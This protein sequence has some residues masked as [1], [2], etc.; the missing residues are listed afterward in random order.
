MRGHVSP[1]VL[2]IA[3]L[4]AVLVLGA[5]WV[6][7][8]STPAPTPSTEPAVITLPTTATVT[9]SRAGAN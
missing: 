2:W 3:A 8:S 5:L 6:L 1:T 9:P 4:L 7:L